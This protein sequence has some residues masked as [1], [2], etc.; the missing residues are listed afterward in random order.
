MPPKSLPYFTSG[1]LVSLKPTII[2]MF[3]TSP[4]S[5]LLPRCP[6]ASKGREGRAASTPSL[7]PRKGGSPTAD[8]WWGGEG[9]LVTWQG[10]RASWGAQGIPQESTQPSRWWHCSWEKSGAGMC[11]HQ[12]V[13][14]QHAHSHL[15]CAE[16]NC[17]RLPPVN[18]L[19]HSSNCCPSPQR[20]QLQ[21]MLFQ[22]ENAGS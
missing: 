10:K 3:A 6:K 18:P 12:E 7:L 1:E 4:G 17:H 5:Q 22:A 20:W 2:P 21:S 9:F 15:S 16:S 13:Q 8:W 14:T 11:V 19:W